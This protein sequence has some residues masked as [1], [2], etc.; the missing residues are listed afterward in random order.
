MANKGSKLLDKFKLPKYYDLEGKFLDIQTDPRGNQYK[1]GWFNPDEL[2]FEYILTNRIDSS[3]PD[4]TKIAIKTCILYFQ[5][6]KMSLPSKDVQ[7][8]DEL[9]NYHNNGNF[10]PEWVKIAMAHGWTPPLNW[11]LVILENSDANIK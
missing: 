9:L 11:K 4:D 1:I 8:N 3:T 7:F 6:K 2:Q 10:I 5:Q